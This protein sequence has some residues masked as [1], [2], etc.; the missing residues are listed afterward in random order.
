[1]QDLINLYIYYRNMQESY[2][3]SFCDEDE[4]TKY[5]QFKWLANAVEREIEARI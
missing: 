5:K 3:N 2:R 4:F 1:M